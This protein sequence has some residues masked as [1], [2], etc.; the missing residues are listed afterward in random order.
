[1]A[2]GRITGKPEVERRGQTT[3]SLDDATPT[4]P[5]LNFVKA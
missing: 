5:N 4:L 3:D 2:I 1:M